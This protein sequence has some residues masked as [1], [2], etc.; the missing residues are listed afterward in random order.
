MNYKLLVIFFIV[1]GF[2]AS[3]YYIYT[4]QGSH[5]M[6]ADVTQISDIFRLFPQTPHDINTKIDQAIAKVRKDIAA[7]LEIKDEERTFA[8][9]AKKIDEI[10]ALSDFAILGSSI[11]ILEMVSPDEKI[12]AAAHE[13]LVRIQDFSVDELS[14]NVQ[15][16]KAFKSYIE[17]NAKAE[18]LTEK[19]WYFLNESLESFKRSGLDLPEEQLD[20][21]KQIKK[22]L[23]LLSLN[24][25]T[26]IAAD[27]RKIIVSKNDLQGVPDDFVNALEKDEQGNYLIVVNPPNFSMI[28]E[29]CAISAVREKMMREYLN[30][31]YPANDALLKEIIAKRDELAH[32]VGKASYAELDLAD[33]M[34]KTPQHAREFL[35]DLLKRVKKKVEQEFALLTQE[36]P[37][38]VVLKEGKML[39]W[40]I[41]Y[42]ANQYKKQHLKIDELK[43]AEYFP[44]DATI[45]GLLSIYEKFF[46]LRFEEE[47]IKGFWHDEVTLL[48]VY[49]T[50]DNV[51]LGYFLLDLFP[52]PFK[53]THACHATVVPSVYGSGGEIKPSVSVV[54]ANFPRATSVDKPALLERNYVST[55]FHEFGHALHALLGRTILSSQAGTAVKCDFVEMPSQMLE[56]WLEEKEILAMISSHYK[57]SEPLP[58]D[59]IEKIV[60][61]KKFDAGAFVQG[62][63]YYALISL[64]LYE[65]GVDKDPYEIMQKL[66]TS[67]KTH[68]VFDTENHMYASFGHLT[69]YGA[70]YYSYL[71]SKVFA[72]DLFAQIK[73]M[74]LLSPVVGEKYVAEVIGQGGSIDPNDLL[75]TFLGRK[76]NQKAFLK[77]LGLSEE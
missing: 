64:N 29:N 72:L 5:K 55:F 70:K 38:S 40:D 48:K 21:V 45:K 17:K 1:I 58:N 68:V 24:F 51:L 69:G 54:I 2:G 41:S 15:L 77:D 30:R 43:I 25:E 62:Q 44:L 76:P 57:T 67:I 66:Y 50:L 22:D 19:E 75:E 60:A 32:K 73:K 36:L 16:F 47:S 28:M 59:L 14:N 27:Q 37:E 10:Y 35:N 20:E 52:R 56:E 4:E 23:A 71:W 49:S 61:L 53:Y 7:V 39:P 12:R 42:T 18:G 74:G 34:V 13:A 63:A 8:N 3:F 26:N 33:Q 65:A 6:Y 31:A 9:T 46:S 11:S